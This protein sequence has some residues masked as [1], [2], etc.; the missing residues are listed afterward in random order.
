MFYW[1]KTIQKINYF[2]EMIAHKQINQNT[3]FISEIVNFSP[4][5]LLI[6]SDFLTISSEKARSFIKKSERVSE[7]IVYYVQI[8]DLKNFSEIK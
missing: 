5:H 7:F 4:L 3:L 1:K 2:K 6:R 8:Y